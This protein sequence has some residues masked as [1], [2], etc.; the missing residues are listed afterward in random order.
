MSYSKCWNWHQIL[1]FWILLI[2]T[3]KKLR[4]NSTVWAPSSYL[5][6][7]LNSKEIKLQRTLLLDPVFSSWKL[8]RKQRFKI[9]WQVR[10]STPISTLWIWY[11][12]RI[13]KSQIKWEILS[14]LLSLLRKPELDRKMGNAILSLKHK[15]KPHPSLV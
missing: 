14:E 7:C 9:R 15:I 11:D 13:I 5:K 4:L 2:S 12:P 6:T 8:K 3:W 10:Y 1:T